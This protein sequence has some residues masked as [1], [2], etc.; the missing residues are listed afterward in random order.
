MPRLSLLQIKGRIG[1]SLFYP[2]RAFSSRFVAKSC[3]W[4]GEIG[5]VYRTIAINGR[6]GHPGSLNLPFLYKV[7][8]SRLISVKRRLE[9]ACLPKCLWSNELK[10]VSISREITNLWKSVSQ[11]GFGE[12]EK[13]GGP[14]GFAFSS[15]FHAFPL[16]LFVAISCLPGGINLILNFQRRENGKKP[17]GREI[18]SQVAKFHQT[19]T[20]IQGC[21]TG[22]GRNRT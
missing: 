2:F 7:R 13:E 17:S 12:L 21:N 16:S 3:S 11:G 4:S 5:L 14:S 9:A 6:V 1:I 18:S 15:R 8:I 20:M 22:V 10:A 19:I